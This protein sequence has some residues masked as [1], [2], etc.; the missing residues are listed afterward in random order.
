MFMAFWIATSTNTVLPK[1]LYLTQP[2]LLMVGCSVEQWTLHQRRP[3]SER[4][5]N[6]SGVWDAQTLLCMRT[7]WRAFKAVDAEPDVTILV[8]EMTVGLGF[9]LKLVAG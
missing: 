6:V 2:T 3:S 9:A 5:N 4:Q 1:F 8:Q 7:N